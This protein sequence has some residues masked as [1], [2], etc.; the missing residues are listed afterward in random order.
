VD[1]LLSLAFPLAPIASA[2]AIVRYGPIR[3]RWWRR[4][5][6]IGFGL[7]VG[8]ITFAIGFVGPMIFAPGANQGPLLG[9]LYTGPLGTLGGLAW[10]IL[11]AVRRRAVAPDRANGRPPRSAEPAR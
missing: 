4:E 2:W 6:P 11:R 8:A 9:I 1:L 7:F 10:G 5:H 3:S